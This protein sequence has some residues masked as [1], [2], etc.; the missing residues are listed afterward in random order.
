[1]F[2]KKKLPRAA[3][4]NQLSK[5]VGFMSLQELQEN[6]PSRIT[7]KEAAAIM[8]VT[9]RFLQLA[10]QQG[11]FPFGTAVKMKRW[12]Y[13]IHAERFIQY[14]LGQRGEKERRK[15]SA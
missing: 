13:Y 6:K 9:P 11:R 1:M 10:L 2:A 8:G 7:V 14:M 4:P 12:S 3:K 5:E 15:D